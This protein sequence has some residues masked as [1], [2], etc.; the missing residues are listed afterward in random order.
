MAS[1][2]LSF[3]VTSVKLHHLELLLDALDLGNKLAEDV[4]ALGQVVNL[5]RCKTAFL[6]QVVQSLRLLLDVARVLSE[7][8]EDLDVVLSIGVLDGLGSGQDLLLDGLESATAGVLGYE[9]VESGDGASSDVKATTN[10]TVGTGLLIEVLDKSILGTA[11]LVGDR[12]LGT[13]REELDGRVALDALLLSSG[14]CVLGFSI[15]LGD[16]DVGFVGVSVGELLPDRSK[17]LAVCKEVSIFALLRERHPLLTSTPRGGEGDNDI[18]VTT[19]LGLE[20]LVVQHL[21]VAGSNGLLLLLQASLLGNEGRQT[22]EVSATV[23]VGGSVALSVEPLEGREALN[24]E[25]TA[26]LLVGI[27]INLCDGDLVLCEFECR[28]QLLVDRSQSLAVTTPGG[29]ELDQSRLSRLEDNVVEVL[30][31]EVDDGRGGRCASQGKGS[32][33]SESHVCD[34]LLL[35]FNR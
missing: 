29:E 16:E 27:G 10:S 34:L 14:L 30:R 32:N 35:L 26:K 15:N 19:N 1:M 25:S 8:V 6:E 18:L 5:L 20:G 11:T 33:Q 12:L 17:S 31:D 28:G 24:T 3:V 7:L 21:D 22:L 23:V 4:A 9:A 13:L 2:F